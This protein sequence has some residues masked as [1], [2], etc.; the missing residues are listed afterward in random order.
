[1]DKRYCPY[2]MAYA[3][4]EEVCP[5]CGRRPSE[6]E[7]APFHLPPGTVLR[8]KYLVGGVLGAGGFGITYVG[9]DMT[10]D[11][12]VAIKEFYPREMASRSTS[13]SAQVYVLKGGAGDGY[14]RGKERFLH[15]AQ[16]LAR[17]EKQPAI[18]R[19]RDFFE[20]NNT[21][22]IVM[23]FVEGVTLKDLV[24]QRGGKV[25]P[26]ELFPLIEPLFKALSVVHGAGLIHRDISP[27]NIMLEGSQVRLLDFGCARDSNTRARDRAPG[28]TC[29]PSAPP[30]IT[31]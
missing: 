16:L 6:Y 4:E 18:V 28:R 24:A 7:A 3:G 23:E 31:A 21:A 29:T 22:Y 9:R 2:C 15:E 20:D 27:D 25:P 1:M 17:L 10:L 30:S 8:N 12:K 11:M 13:S 19:V 14:Q 26:E 5:A